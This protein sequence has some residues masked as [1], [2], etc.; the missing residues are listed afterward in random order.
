MI[1]AVEGA[2]A[3]RACR[4]EGRRM[5]SKAG[6]I[7]GGAP[8]CDHRGVAWHHSGSPSG[9]RAAA[10]DGEDDGPSDGRA[11]STTA[12]SAKAWGNSRGPGAS[13]A[14]NAIGATPAQKDVCQ[15]STGVNQEVSD[16]D[17][18][19]NTINSG[20]HKCALQ[21]VAEELQRTAKKG[22]YIAVLPARPY[23]DRDLVDTGT[24]QLNPGIPPAQWP[25]LPKK[26]LVVG[27]SA[28][29]AWAVASKALVVH[30][31]VQEVAAIV[32]VG[33]RSQQ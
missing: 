26:V 33:H 15:G 22:V 32:N 31:G 4:S 3:A 14:K 24:T 20:S 28:E 16:S 25:A 9:D 30:Q 11:G 6:D 10:Q 12:V 1:D 27:R 17:H 5:R 21:P 19:G 18:S 23:R 7:F 2:N 29:D 13:E 8:S